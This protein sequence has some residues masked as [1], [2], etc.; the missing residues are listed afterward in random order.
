MKISAHYIIYSLLFCLGI[1]AYG[2]SDTKE[3][4]HYTLIDT[5]QHQILPEIKVFS[6]PA[7]KNK[8]QEKYYWRL[9]RDVKKT[10]PYAKQIAA[11]VWEIN[12]TLHLIENEK[13]KRKFLKIKE[14]QLFSDFETPMKGLTFNQGM[15]LIKLVDRECSETSYELVKMYRGGF[16][17]FFWQSFAVL[18]GGN[19]KSEYNPQEEDFIIEHVINMVEI[20]IF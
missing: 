18:L 9:V 13:E 10:L 4:Q 12:D 14:K 7:F 5:T 1:T 3:W 19:L 20:G 6:R 2:Q 11:I 15:L 8:R 16:T 17:A